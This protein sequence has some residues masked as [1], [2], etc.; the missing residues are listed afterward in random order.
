MQQCYCPGAA[1]HVLA[2]LLD[3]GALQAYH[4]EQLER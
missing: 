1:R 4:V 3:I 2:H